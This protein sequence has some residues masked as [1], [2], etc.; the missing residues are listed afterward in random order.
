MALLT[1]RML[2][3][4]TPR[5]RF[6]T[7]RRLTTSDLTVDLSPQ[8]SERRKIADNITLGLGIHRQQVFAT[9]PIQPKPTRREMKVKRTW[10]SWWCSKGGQPPVDQRA[11]CL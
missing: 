8:R 9:D 6:R 5:I 7:G 11:I 1:A 10:K 3:A 2:H 4:V